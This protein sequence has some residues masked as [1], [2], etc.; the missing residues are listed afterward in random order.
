MRYV[1]I[2]TVALMAGLL[3]GYA[4]RPVPTQAKPTVAPRATVAH[5]RPHSPYDGAT[6]CQMTGPARVSCDNGYTGP[7]A[8]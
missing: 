3:W 7:Y 5:P 8:G 6:W 4:T 1:V 2:A